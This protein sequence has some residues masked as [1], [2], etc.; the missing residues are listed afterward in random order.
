M[1]ER[2]IE[3]ERIQEIVTVIARSQMRDAVR[4]QEL[5][6]L[7][8]EAWA[9]ILEARE[10][11]R[12]RGQEM[13]EGL[14]WRV[15]KLQ[16]LRWKLK[17]RSVL[18]I[19][20]GSVNKEAK[21]GNL[22]VGMELKDFLEVGEKGRGARREAEIR[23]LLKMVREKIEKRLG[24]IEKMVMRKML[25]GGSR[26]EAWEELERMGVKGAKGLAYGA[27]EK[28]KAEWQRELTG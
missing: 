15:A 18:S 22:K 21:K 25:E 26:S 7:V 19:P 27:A 23:R 4:N 14:V 16:I 6:E 9:G 5:K 20:E 11:L 3:A 24:W 28:I 10:R 8:N 13:N 2:E 12:A 1:K 17:M